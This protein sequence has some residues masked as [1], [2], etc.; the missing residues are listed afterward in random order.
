VSTFE[1]I[2]DRDQ[3]FFMEMNTR[4]QVEH[5]VTE[6]CYALRFA[7]PDNAEDYFVVESLVEAMVLLAAHGPRLPRARPACRGNDSVEARL[8][9]T[10]QALQPS[11]GGIIEYWSDAIEGEIRDD[12]G[13]SLHNPDTDVFMKYTLAGAY[14]SNIALLLTVGE[15][16]L[17]C[18][19]AHGRGDP[20]D[21][22]ARQ[23]PGDEPRIPLRPGELVH[24]PHI[25][26]SARPRALSC[27]TSRPSANSSAKPRS[28]DLP[29]AWRSCASASWR[30]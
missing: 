25:N 30:R 10:N 19:R 7:N 4:I 24:R 22:D 27:R 14:D 12:Q 29:H 26:A 17:D 6:L 28:I 15:T 16:R 5:R 9:A 18:Y 13:I 11:A 3:H 2:V 20:P 23:G 8:N 1:C 21:H